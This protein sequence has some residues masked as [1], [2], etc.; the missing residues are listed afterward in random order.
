MTDQKKH[1][2]NSDTK[3]KVKVLSKGRKAA[4]GGS[5]SGPKGPA[6]KRKKKTSVDVKSGRGGRKKQLGKSLGCPEIA[7]F[8]LSDIHPATYNPRVISDDNLEGL[9]KSLGSYGCVELIIVN[10]RDGRN[11]IIGGHQRYRVLKAEGALECLCVTVDLDEADEKL[12][13]LALNNP[14][15]QGE[16]IDRI[17]EYIDGLMAD[18]DRPQDFLDLR[19]AL[20]KGG[21]DEEEKSG[22]ILDDEVPEPSEKIV[23]VKGDLWILGDHRLLCGDSTNPADVERLMAGHKASLF[24]TDP[25][26]CV[27]YTGKDRPG[28][29]KDWSGKYHET[30]I[31]DAGKFI[32][33]FYTI[34]LQHTRKNVPL[35]LWH[36]S[37]RRHEIEHACAELKI[38]IHQDIIWVKPC[39]VL[40]YSFYAWRHEPCLLMWKRGQKPKFRPQTKSIGTIWAVGFELEGDP[41]TPEYYSDVWEVDWDGSKRKPGDIEHPTVKPVEL[42]ARPMRI[43][44]RPGDICYEPFCGSGTQIIAAEKLKRKCYAMEQEPVFCD[45]TVKRWEKWTGRKAKRTG[46]TKR[47]GRAKK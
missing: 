24:A 15:I 2:K 27:D 47:A 22:K 23:T 21:M 12:L 41:T 4:G 30:N 8:Q 42:F 18:I 11:I 33:D 36:A 6:A 29:G 19:I 43:H 31:P 1:A 17:G 38:L 35:Y 34:G 39:I 9:A 32:M 14:A 20:I 13:N 25:P 16:F 28:G 46:K 45:V 7:K 5:K 3:P 44:T 37:R 26:Y 40:G 10:V